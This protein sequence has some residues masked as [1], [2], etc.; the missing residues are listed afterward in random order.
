[1][2]KTVYEERSRFHAADGPVPFPLLLEIIRECGITPEL[3][4]VHTEIERGWES[5]DDEAVL[6]ISTCREETEEEYEERL[7]E[8][9]RRGFWHDLATKVGEM[10]PKEFAKSLMDAGIIGED[11]RLTKPYR[12]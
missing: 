2:K 6:V 8:E 7:H 9:G 4:Y 1:M 10:T 5:C 11:G 3:A 12:Q